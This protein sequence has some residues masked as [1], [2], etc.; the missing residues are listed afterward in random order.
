MTPTAQLTRSGTE[1]YVE[2]RTID[3]NGLRNQTTG[4]K[5]PILWEQAS[6]SQNQYILK[7]SCQQLVFRTAQIW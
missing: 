6:A 5:Q 4:K 1:A 3:K 7:Y 2:L